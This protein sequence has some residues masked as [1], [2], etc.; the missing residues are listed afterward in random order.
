VVL[1]SVVIA[2]VTTMLVLLN[3]AS[4]G[5]ALSSGSWSACARD[6]AQRMA[7]D[8]ALRISI[9]ARNDGYGSGVANNTVKNLNDAGIPTSQIQ[10]IVYDLNAVSYNT[11]VDDVRQFNPDAIAVI[12]F[13]ESPKIIVRLMEV[14]I[15]PDQKLLYATDPDSL[16]RSTIAGLT[17]NSTPV[18]FVC[19][20]GAL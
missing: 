18:R 5:T 20:P 15:G 16:S 3:Q 10:E 7:G 12:G 9:L 19:V 2:I 14:R 11:E 17:H 1:L 8:G 13:D 6:L 4:T